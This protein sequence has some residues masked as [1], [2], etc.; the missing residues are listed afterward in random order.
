M[1]RTWG[2]LVFLLQQHMDAR[3]KRKM[4]TWTTLRRFL[5]KNPLPVTAAVLFRLSDHP[6]QDRWGRR[7]GVA[8]LSYLVLSRHAGGRGRNAGK[9]TAAGAQGIAE[10]AGMDLYQGREGIDVAIHPL[11]RRCVPGIKRFPSSSPLGKQ[12]KNPLI[13][14]GILA[15]PGRSTP[16][17]GGYSIPAKISYTLQMP[18]WMA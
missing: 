9:F 11:I 1:E 14:P 8:I 15:R 12:E 10:K 5:K 7:A 16:R 17:S 4:M 18:W 3:T 6:G 13:F 2:S